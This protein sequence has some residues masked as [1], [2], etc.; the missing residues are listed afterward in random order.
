MR[1][2]LPFLVVGLSSGAI[3]GLA[4]I[5]LVLTYRTAGVFNFA[6]GAVAA[7]GAYAFYELRTT[8]GWPWPVALVVSVLAVA[9]VGG[10]AIAWLTRYL[11]GA[12]T[13]MQLVATAGLLLFVWGCMVWEVGGTTRTLT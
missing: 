2:L 7:L 12:R 8:H 3:Y 4:G 13:E 10:A 5:G 1:D 11:A 9:V 6:H